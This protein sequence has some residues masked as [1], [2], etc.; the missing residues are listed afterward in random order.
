MDVKKKKVTH[1]VQ[2]TPKVK[3]LKPV[4]IYLEIL[5]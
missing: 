3:I 1:P 5:V 2:M 4:E